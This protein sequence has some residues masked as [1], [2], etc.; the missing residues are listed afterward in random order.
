[1]KAL[2]IVLLCGASCLAAGAASAQDAT[3]K[4]EAKTDAITEV[5]VTAQKRAEVASKTPIAIT[6]YSGDALKNQGVV[7]VADIQNIAPSV[8]IGKDGFG[9]NINIRGVTTTDTTSKGEQGIAF[10]VDGVPLGR[11]TEMGLA[12]FDVQRVEVLRGPQGTLYG[13]SSTGGAINVITNK[14]S[15]HFEASADGE[16]GS[17]NTRR[18]N[19]MLNVPANDQLAFRFALNANKRDGYIDLSQGDTSSGTRARNDEDNLNGRLSMLYKPNA[20]F[21]WLMTYTAGQVRGEGQ[22]AVPYLTVINNSGKAQLQAFANPFGGGTHE[23]YGNLSTQLDAGLGAVHATLVAAH[24]HFE[25]DDRTSSTNDPDGNTSGPASGFYAWR[26]YAGTVNTDYAELRFSNANKGRLDWVV[27]LNYAREDIHESDHNWNAP[28]ATPTYADSQNGIDPVNQ[29]VHASSGV[30]AQATWHVTDR[31]NLTAGARESK[32]EVR[33]DGTFAAGPGPW[34]DPQGNTCVAPSDC[35]GTPNNGYQSAKKPTWRLGADYQVAPN[36]MIYASVATGYKA[37]GF[38]DFD[39]STGGSGAYAPEQLTAYEAGY[40]G[41][42]LPNLQYN[43]DVFYYDYSSSQV[44]SLENIQGNFV[45]Y[46]RSVPVKISGWE[47]ELHWRPTA[48]DTVDASLV[49]ESSHYVRFM[50]G[51]LADVDWSGRSLD[52]TPGTAGT[53]GYSHVFDLPDDRNIVFHVQSKYSS[54]FLLSDIQNA[55]QYKQRPFTRSDMTLTYNLKGGDMYVQ[56]YVKNLE[57]KVQM[58]AAPGNY[59]AAVPLSA[60]VGVTEPRMFGVRFGARY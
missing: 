51:L 15:Q 9:V 44:S 46:T 48:N 36:Q 31:L 52:K 28:I 20:D 6:A 35:I 47:N 22:G 45:I 10:N 50:A 19:L 14:P 3:Q 55:L 32:D 54:A 12:F 37:G 7:S 39:P 40:K 11:P 33:R 58:L 23:D 59:N 13:K 18:A 16:L 42:L 30:F 41:R 57:N 60:S 5:I 53:F 27:G 8:N 34:P 29:T 4:P 1:M 24:L 49:F 2:R 43:T 17:Y 38:N 56:A 25:A 26:E 21:S